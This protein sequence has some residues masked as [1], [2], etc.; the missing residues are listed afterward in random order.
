MSKKPLLF[1]Y[2]SHTSY[3]SLMKLI[4]N[5]LLLALST[6]GS[7]FKRELIM[8]FQTVV[9][10]DIQACFF[11]KV[12]RLHS[13]RPWKFVTFSLHLQYVPLL[14]W[15]KSWLIIVLSDSQEIRI[16]EH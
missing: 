10:V 1:F 12:F 2:V 11:A 16:L 5:D 13:V 15:D 8:Q 4:V 6:F 3:V 9:A 7:F 14:V